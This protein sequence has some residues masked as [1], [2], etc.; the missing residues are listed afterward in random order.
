[1]SSI[2]LRWTI[3][4]S[5]G[6]NSDDCVLAV[7]NLT[8]AFQTNKHIYIYIYQLQGKIIQIDMTKA[9]SDFNQQTITIVLLCHNLDIYSTCI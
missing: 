9:S 7:T 4:S 5:L 1:M 6:L 8:I 2:S 3:H